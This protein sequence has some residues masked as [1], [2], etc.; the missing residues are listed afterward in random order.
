MPIYEYYSKDTNKIYSFYAKSSRYKDIIPQCPDNPDYSMVKMVSNFAFIGGTKKAE[1]ENAMGGGADDM[2]MNDPKM[3][4]AMAEMERAIS[5]M[6]EDNP[7]PRQM[8]QLM[9]KMA[10]MTGEKMDAG[11][12]EVIA[13]LEEGRDPEELEAE[14]GDLLGDDPEMGGMG[15]PMGQPGGDDTGGENDNSTAGKLKQLLRNQRNR[16]NAPVKDPELYEYSEADLK[17][18]ELVQ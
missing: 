6:D 4:A 11:M 12:E 1:E 14:M 18:L 3:R 5:S 2:D 7:D 17:Q 16:Q 13:K 15:G 9:R 10:E 8:G